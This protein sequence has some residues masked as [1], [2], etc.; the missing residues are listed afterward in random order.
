MTAK[1]VP[2]A[3]GTI[4]FGWTGMPEGVAAIEIWE[5]EKR[6]RGAW[7]AGA[8]RMSDEYSLEILSPT[9]TR[10]RLTTSG[11]DH[12]PAADAEYRCVRIGWIF[13]L[14]GLRHMLER[15]MGTPR[16]IAWARQRASMPSKE[17]MARLLGPDG[18]GI[19]TEGDIAPGASFVA[20]AAAAGASWSGEVRAYDPEAQFVGVVRELN[21]ALL[22]VE[23]SCDMGD[24]SIEAWVW[25]SCYGVDETAV[26][27]IEAHWS[28]R[29]AALLKT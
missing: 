25:L 21:D 10:V 19:R 17:I 26:R 14:E 13:E 9:R 22:R 27:Q 20:A 3:G 18:L 15:H 28:Q 11:F 7:P 2:G 6:L 12:G 5:P 8:P 16:I 1:V 24:G 23:A 29:L 4:T